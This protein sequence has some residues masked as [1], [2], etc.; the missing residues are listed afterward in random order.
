VSIFSDTRSKWTP[1]VARSTWE[2]NIISKYAPG[3][4]RAWNGEFASNDNEIIQAPPPPGTEP[5]TWDKMN[6][7]D[8]IVWG[9][10]GNV[11]ITS[12]DDNP[13]QPNYK[14]IRGT[15]SEGKPTTF[16]IS[17]KG[18]YPIVVSGDTAEG[19]QKPSITPAGTQKPDEGKPLQTPTDISELKQAVADALPAYAAALAE[20][21][22]LKLKVNAAEF[23]AEREIGPNGWKTE[24]EIKQ[25]KKD[26]K[27]AKNDLAK[28]DAKLI[29]TM[30]TLGGS[31][32]AYIDAEVQQRIDAQGITRMTPDQ[33]VEMLKEEARKIEDAAQTPELVKERDA[34]CKDM[35]AEIRAGFSDGTLTSGWMMSSTD[36]DETILDRLRGRY[37]S[38]EHT[39]VVMRPGRMIDAYSPSPR[40]ELAM[41]EYNAK[42]G[43]QNK[44]MI[45]AYNALREKS[46]N[47][48]DKV[49]AITSAVTFETIGQMREMSS[50]NDLTYTL[51]RIGA[52]SASDDEK[53]KEIVASAT[54]MFPKDWIDDVNSKMPNGIR[55]EY[56]FS[57]AGR[58]YHQ[59]D[60]VHLT[61]G[62]EH[63]KGDSAK[64]STTLHEI[65]HYL[66]SASGVQSTE[67]SFWRVRCPKQRTSQDV[68]GGRG[69]PDDF[70]IK[71]AGRWYG[72]GNYEIMTMGME[73]LYAGITERSTL[74]LDDPQYRNFMVGTLL[75]AGRK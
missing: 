74:T 19:E 75:L 73:S 15:T 33:R 54:Q 53:M 64:I 24:D 44:A 30:T 43:A 51:S 61:L 66:E 27:V 10:H 23:E 57:E 34:I 71:Y 8:T 41:N 38:Q 4:E 29:D 14:R 37:I 69:D 59:R 40:I 25:S 68:V 6:V 45:D 72:G 17:L 50:G 67:A 1:I 58:S 20:V 9:R 48:V 3:Q 47:D 36:S 42:Y 5:R 11:K 26:Y 55:V 2:P 12:I 70:K 49:L 21:N 28:A 7:G 16:Y 60:C 31:V 62:S 22:D 13:K 18:Q 52:M 35:L 56:T 46:R 65:M 63:K 32:N 39:N